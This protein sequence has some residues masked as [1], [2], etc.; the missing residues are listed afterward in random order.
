MN[1]GENTSLDSEVRLSPIVCLLPR[2]ISLQIVIVLWMAIVLWIGVGLRIGIVLRNAVFILVLG[3]SCITSA[4]NPWTA[5]SARSVPAFHTRIKLCKAPDCPV[6]AVAD[7]A[8][9]EHPIKGRC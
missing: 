8:V 2:T 6:C 7:A 4:T 3:S 5:G 9:V 1:A